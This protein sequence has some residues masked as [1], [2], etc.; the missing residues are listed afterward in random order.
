MAGHLVHL[1][2]V[3]GSP[4]SALLDFLLAFFLYDKPLRDDANIGMSYSISGPPKVVV[5]C[6]LQAALASDESLSG[7][8]PGPE[9][10][11]V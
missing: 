6:N 11:G 1:N 5:V 10:S 8:L 2:R 4:F 9:S 7:F 3:L